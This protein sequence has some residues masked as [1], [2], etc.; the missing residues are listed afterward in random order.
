MFHPVPQERAQYLILSKSTKT[1]WVLTEIHEKPRKDSRVLHSGSTSAKPVLCSPSQHT[2]FPQG[3]ALLASRETL[4][5]SAVCWMPFLTLPRK[6][7]FSQWLKLELLKGPL[8]LWS[9]PLYCLG[10]PSTQ[11]PSATGSGNEVEEYALAN[12]TSHPHPNISH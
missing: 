2:V 6:A 12:I 7:S 11:L 4:L 10:S 9:H 5:W 3:K 8:G 1:D